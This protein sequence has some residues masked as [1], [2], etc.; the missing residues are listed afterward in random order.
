MKAIFFDLDGTLIDSGDDL[1]NAINYMLK[2]LN[3]K[4][5]DNELIKSWV[6]NGAKTLVQRA[7]N[8][9]DDFEKGYKIFMD[10]YSKNLSLH[11]KLYPNAKE[12]LNKLKKDYKLVLITNK[13]Y[14]FVH[15]ILETLDINLFEIVLGGDSLDEKKPSAKPLLYCLEKLNLNPKD[16]VMVGDSKN[17]ILSAQKANIKSIALTHG[18]NYNED[19]KAYNPDIIIDNLK[20]LLCLK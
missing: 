10:Y 20:E 3:K 13:P 11:T 12:V 15:P 6:G 8:S 4:T 2:S 7:L 17:D 18:Y 1:A 9:D 19:I 14:K 5:F 16:V